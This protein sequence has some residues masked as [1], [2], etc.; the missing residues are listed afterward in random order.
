MKISPISILIVAVTSLFGP[1]IDVPLIR[2]AQ[3]A[4]NVPAGD[5]PKNLQ[6]LSKDL[7]TRQVRAMMEDWTGELGVDC[8]TC[9]VRSTADPSAD[10]HERFNYADDSKQEKRTARVMYA[11]T[12]EINAR[13][14]STV[15]NSGVPVTCGTCH[16]GHLSPVPYSGD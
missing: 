5:Q 4:S 12:A 11:M 15:P 16:R 9:H 13:Y 7:S 3:A 14:V 6:V 2:G 1:V 10:G 8:S